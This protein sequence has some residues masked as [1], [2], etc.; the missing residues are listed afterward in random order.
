MQGAGLI[1]FFST[2][3]SEKTTLDYSFDHKDN[4][5]CFMGGGWWSVIFHSVI[6]LL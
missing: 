4:H 1:L 6:Q 3:F 2:W 5:M